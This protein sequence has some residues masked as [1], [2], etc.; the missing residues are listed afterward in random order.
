MEKVTELVKETETVQVQVMKLELVK[1]TEQETAQEA[2]MEK[3][4]ETAIILEALT[5]QTFQPILM[6]L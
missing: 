5:F 2:V 4:M 6:L 1:A 3:V